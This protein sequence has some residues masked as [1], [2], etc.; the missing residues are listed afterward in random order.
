MASYATS[1]AVDRNAWVTVQKKTFTRW[2]NMHL[3]K[4]SMSVEDLFVDTRD[5][6]A[7]CNLLEIIGGESIKAVTG[8]KFNKKP[9]FEIHM[10]ENGN[11]VLEYC[12]KR[13]LGL[14]NVGSETC[15]VVTR[16]LFWDS[17]GR[18]S[19]GSSSR[20]GTRGVAFV[21]ATRMQKL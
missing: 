7:W 19:S 20:R 4:R 1:N 16:K 21:G 13:E 8:N 9:K 3:K 5:G 15:C 17:F 6:V 12:E 14:V 10:G 2:V 11:R 18:S